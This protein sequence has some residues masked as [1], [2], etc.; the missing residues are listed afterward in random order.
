[1][2]KKIPTSQAELGMYLQSMEGSWLSHPFWKT[3]FLLRDPADLDALVRSGVPFIW[4]DVVK[5]KDVPAS[6]AEILPRVEAPPAPP[7]A[8]SPP[9]AAPAPTPVAAA[10]VKPQSFEEELERA[11]ELMQNSKRQVASM[12]EEARLGRTIKEEDCLPVVEDIAGSVWRNPSALISLA[13]L[14]QRDDYTYMHSVAVCA[15]MVSLGKQLGLSEAEQRQAGLAGLLHDVGKMLVPLEILNKPGS[16]TDPE[17]AVMRSHPARGY[18]AL[19]A[20]GVFAEPVLDVCLHHHEKIDGTGYPHRLKAD[21]I[22]LFSR[23][24]SVC[25]VYDAV[26]SNRPYKNAWDP[27]GSIARMAQWQGHFDPKIFQ[28]FVVS[29]G[30]YPVGTLVRLES[31]RMAVVIDQNPGRLTTPKVRVFFST[32]SNMPIDVHDVDLAQ[33]GDKVVG[34]E[35]PATWGF[36][37]INELWSQPR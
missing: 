14:K 22:S 27:A 35:D 21:Q 5:G 26:T 37:H 1:M 36:T 30:I 19:R 29:I 20:S 18:E 4:I 24:G 15:M 13:R 2:L 34:R 10:P 23:M 16:L 7:P 32:K 3:K 6:A 8:P 17:F 28:A 12:F 33:T 11:A 9:A 31:G 25:D